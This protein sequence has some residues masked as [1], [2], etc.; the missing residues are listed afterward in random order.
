[1]KIMT[2]LSVDAQGNMWMSSEMPL[3]MGDDG[4]LSMELESPG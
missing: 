1:M 2:S 3:T 4:Q